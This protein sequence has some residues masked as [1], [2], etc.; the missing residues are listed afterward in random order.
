M[1]PD[2]AVAGAKTGEKTDKAG[3]EKTGEKKAE[4]TGEKAVVEKAVE[5]IGKENAP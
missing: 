2:A 5:K 4:K 1:K 3:V